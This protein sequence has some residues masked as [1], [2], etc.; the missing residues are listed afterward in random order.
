MAIKEVWLGSVGPFLYDDA[1]VYDDGESVIGVRAEQ[2]TVE[3]APSNNTE[4][5][6]KIDID[7][8]VTNH[9]SQHQNGG[10]DEINV[11]GLSG[12]LADDQHVLN[13]EVLA[14][15]AKKGSNSDITSTSALHSIG[16]TLNVTGALTA[17]SYADNTPGFVGDA[18]SEIMLIKTVDG[19]IDHSTLP[20]F[21]RKQVVVDG[22][23]EEKRDLG[24]MVSMLVVAIQQLYSK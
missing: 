2:I 15:A 24:A 23:V 19:E 9:A 8:A 20:D 22:K 21:A 16:G 5:L 12:L 1:D 17:A 14:V 18:L 7:T 3:N 11:G 4:V 6:R 13:S 10:S